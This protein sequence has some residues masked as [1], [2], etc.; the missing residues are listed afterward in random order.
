MKNK[1]ENLKA[2]GFNVNSLQVKNVFFLTRK[3][4]V[5]RPIQNLK[6]NRKKRYA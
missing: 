3:I 4:K 2:K 6:L 1:L 5:Y